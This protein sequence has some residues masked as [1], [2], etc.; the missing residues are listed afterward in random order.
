MTS[1][2]KPLEV[3]LFNN[4]PLFSISQIYLSKELNLLVVVSNFFYYSNFTTINSIKMITIIQIF[5]IFHYRYLFSIVL[6]SN[7]VDI[8]DL[9]FCI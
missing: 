1:I 6:Y 5:T 8:I 9:V 4:V 7:N 3:I 2:I